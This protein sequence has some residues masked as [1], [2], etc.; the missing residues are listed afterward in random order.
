MD[1]LTFAFTQ[2]GL[3]AVVNGTEEISDLEGLL[4]RA[5]DVPA[6]VLAQALTEFGPAG[7]Q[8]ITDPAAFEE[9]FR[10]RLAGEDPNEPW[11]EGMMRLRDFGIPD[12]TEIAP[13]KIEDGTLVYFARALFNGLPYRTKV[14]LGRV[15]DVTYLPLE[16]TPPPE[17]SPPVPDPVA[18]MPG[19]D[20]DD[21]DILDL[22]AI[23][24]DD[25][26]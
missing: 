24:D 26:P 11:R 18:T 1:E 3:V 21:S 9:A 22:D 19:E 5:P 4:T 8:V 16:L 17:P 10:T 23:E 7:F 25:T 15:G 14:T 20:D 2:D 12:F 13:P 6:P